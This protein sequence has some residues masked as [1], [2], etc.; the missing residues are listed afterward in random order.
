M[1]TAATRIS[2][3]L[4]GTLGK[5][6]LVA[7]VLEQDA[8]GQP[9]AVEVRYPTRALSAVER[10][11]HDLQTTM[12]LLYPAADTSGWQVRLDPAHDR[13]ILTDQPDPLAEP[14]ALPTIET[15]PA[16]GMADGVVIGIDEQGRPLRVPLMGGAHVLV[17]GATGAGKG[18]ILWGTIRG[19][20]PMLIDGSVRLSVIDPKGGQEFGPLAGLIHRFAISDDEALALLREAC[21]MLTIKARGMAARGDRSVERPT[22]QT[23]LDL[24][25][26]DELAALTDHPVAKVRAEVVALTSKIMRQGRSAGVTLMAATQDPRTRVVPNRSMYTYA[27]AMRLSEAGETNMILGHGARAQ[28]ALADLIPHALPGVCYTVR[29]G[30]AGFTRGRAAYVSSDDIDQIAFALGVSVPAPRF[31]RMAN[32]SEQKPKGW[33]KRIMH[34]LL[35]DPFNY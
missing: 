18:S 34:S 11:L 15:T 29:D 28:G 3:A 32:D 14:V 17:A 22:P 33:R 8:D 19:L 1:T 35:A 27:V 21:E 20:L 16:L 4:S 26:I 25:I 24:I 2:E 5:H 31:V 6:A 7:T 10:S 23:P 12:G 9:Q 30:R 13:M